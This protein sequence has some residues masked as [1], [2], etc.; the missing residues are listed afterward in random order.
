MTR[1]FG[2][3]PKPTTPATQRKIEKFSRKGAVTGAGDG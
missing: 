2:Y 1:G 3:T